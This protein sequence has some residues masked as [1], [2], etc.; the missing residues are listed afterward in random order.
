MSASCCHHTPSPEALGRRKRG[1]ERRVLWIAL[2]VNAGM[3]LV[4]VAAGSRA[5][6]S[7]LQA[8]ALDFLGD[9]ANYAVSLLVVG[10]TVRSRAHVALLKGGTMGL[11]G[12][13]VLVQTVLQLWRGDVPHAE[14]MGGVGLLALGANVAVLALLTSFRRGDA[15]LRSVW[16][17]SRN[18]VLGNLAVLLAAGGVVTTR[19]G[20]PDA[21]VA[22]VMAALAIHAAWQ[23]VTS[24]SRELQRIAPPTTAPRRSPELQ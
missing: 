12:V 23:V 20:A 11:F 21:I 7:S 5:G 10:A 6:S 4:E 2:V 16:L 24:A 17:C 9:A 22:I 15:N 14:V 19:T 8:D 13:W 1:R 3:F 18:D